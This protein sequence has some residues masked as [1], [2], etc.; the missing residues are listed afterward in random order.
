MKPVA[1]SLNTGIAI[2]SMT[3]SNAVFAHP[4]HDHGHWASDTTHALLAL[5]FIITTGLGVYCLRK[6]QQATANKEEN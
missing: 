5:S 6:A 1:R 3:L 2:A 4:G